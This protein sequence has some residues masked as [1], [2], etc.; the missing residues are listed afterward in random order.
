MTTAK[1]T[2]KDAVPATPVIAGFKGFDKNMQCRGF[3]FK[4]GETYQHKGTASA[5]NSGFH[6]CENP[7]DVFGYYPPGESVFHEVAGSGQTDKHNDD[8]KVG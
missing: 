2:K 4:E 7:L 8:S 6:F 1:K 3:Q 5:C